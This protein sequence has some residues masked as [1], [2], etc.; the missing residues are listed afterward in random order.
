MNRRLAAILFYD[1]VGYSRAM[2]QDETATISALKQTF[3]QVIQ[4]LAKSHNGRMIKVMGD[5]GFMEFSSAVE[6]VHF[7]ICM[8]HA[9]GLSELHQTEGQRLSYRIGINIGDVVADDDDLFG[10]GVNIAARLESLA[11]P[12]G[13]CVH[14]SVRDQIRGKLHLDFK[15]L[16]AITVKNIDKPVH[17]ATIEFNHLTAIVAALPVEQS[18][19]APSSKTRWN[20]AAVMAAG[21][22]ILGGLGWS[23]FQTT[24]PAPANL[25]RT[26]L[27]L[28]DK[29]SLA[30]LPFANLSN[31]PTQ[32][33]FSDG[34]TEDLITDLS[35]ISGLFVVARNSTF[36]YK[37]Q[38][39]NIPMVAKELG[40]QYVLEGSAR[41]SG[42]QVRVNAQLIDA[43]TGGHIWAE[44]YDG[45]VTDIFEVQDTFIR[46]IAKAL[47]INL[48]E[49]EEQEIALGQTTDILAREVF[50][51]GWESFLEYSAED[52]ANAVDQFKQALE[53]DPNYGRAHAALSLAYLRGCQLRWN[54]P[55]GLSAGEANAY[56]MSA[57]AETK[58]LPSSLGNV[59][60]SGVNLYNSRY[61]IAKTDA[62]RAIA[63]DP[64]DPEAFIAMAWA[65]ITTGQP[66]LGLD[67]VDQAMRLNPT[68]PSYY[69][70]AQAMAHY[71]MGELE[72]SADVLSKALERDPNAKQLAVIAAATFAHLQRFDEANAAI[73]LALPKAG[74]KELSALPYSYHFPFTW[75]HNPEIVTN[76]INGLHLAALPPDDPIGYLQNRLETGNTSQRRNVA[77]ILGFPELDAS[78]TVPLLTLALVDESKVVKNQA[79]KS[80]EQ[81]G[82][83][84]KNALPT[85]MK[86]TDGSL[87][88]RKAQNAIKAIERS[89]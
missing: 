43:T 88:G 47:A 68:Y 81:I 74:Q 31:D 58:R 6:A 89:D 26:A 50:Q 20:L 15:D 41:R 17:A 38:S 21:L 82:P 13:I 72:Q 30:V 69:V 14:Q 34:L 2:G 76:V 60:A 1:I 71:S 16:G 53:I 48:T 62:T 63:T 75:E 55:L 33:G 80:L 54:K 32:E 12:G 51:S 64:N 27:P 84:A 36:V 18:P 39:V 4:P 9:I 40:V 10:D 3:S 79:I 44:R 57:L 42:D 70:F 52:N 45:D 59:A 25:E 35:R 73:R 37:G 56:A 7:A 83:G 24:G 19:N 87:T 8:Q 49:E 77:M 28:P 65:M 78:D 61:D 46:K 29:P 67:L 5:G 22:V 66:K 23:Q 86:M 85:L 11:E